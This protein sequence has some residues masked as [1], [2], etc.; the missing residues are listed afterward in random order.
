MQVCAKLPDLRGED[1][2][3]SE[4]SGQ[5]FAASLTDVVEAAEAAVWDA[6]R[7]S[8]ETGGRGIHAAFLI[9]LPNLNAAFQNCI[10]KAKSP[11]ASMGRR[12]TI[13]ITYPQALC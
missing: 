5:R 13:V 12:M 11:L 1:L 8:A 4:R 9:R 7:A 10:Y 3:P 6:R 2:S